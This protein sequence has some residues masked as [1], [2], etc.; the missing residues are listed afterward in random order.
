MPAIMAR[1]HIVCLPSLYGEGVPRVLI[2][3][4][5]CGRPIVTTDTPGC[6]EIVNNSVNGFLVPVRDATAVADA[7]KKLIES[8]ALRREMGARGRALVEKEFTLEKVNRE[9]LILYDELL[10]RHSVENRDACG[11]MDTP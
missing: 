2:E 3:A 6:R 11:R 5:S 1:A 9:T 10:I 7:L 4:A 8:P